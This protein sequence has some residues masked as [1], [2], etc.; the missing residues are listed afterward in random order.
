MYV[1]TR[2]QGPLKQS[3]SP[4]D[5][6]GATW[7]QTEP[8]PDLLKRTFSSPRPDTHML[9]TFRAGYTQTSSV[10]QQGPLKRPLSRRSD[11]TLIHIKVEDFLI[12]CS[13]DRQ[14]ASFGAESFEGRLPEER[15][16][17]RMRHRE[18]YLRQW[19]NIFF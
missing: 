4:H 9:L 18:G 19:T 1:G 2:R 3:W 13:V 17:G 6:P 5:H 11:A 14:Q 12:E 10:E 8:C 7:L 16:A 15:L